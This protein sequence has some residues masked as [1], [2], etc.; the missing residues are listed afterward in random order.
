[1]L[2]AAGAGIDGQALIS[3]SGQREIPPKDRCPCPARDRIAP[4][5]DDQASPVIQ[6]QC[7]HCFKTPTAA[8]APH[9]SDALDERADIDIFKAYSQNELD[10]RLSTA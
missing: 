7:S 1:L 5:F 10:R 4:E 3:V 2:I 9:V 8:A 6:C